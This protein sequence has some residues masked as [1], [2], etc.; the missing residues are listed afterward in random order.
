MINVVDLQQENAQL[1]QQL[2]RQNQRIQALEELLMQS[3]HQ[4]FAPRSEKLNSDQLRLFNEAE[5]RDLL[6]PRGS[7]SATVRD[8]G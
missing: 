1:K 2:T 4:Q 6:H 7:H 3:R 8:L 5:P